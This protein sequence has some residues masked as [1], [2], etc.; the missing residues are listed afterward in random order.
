MSSYLS[1]NQSSQFK[2][3]TDSRFDGN[4]N[5]LWL[6]KYGWYRNIASADNINQIFRQDSHIQ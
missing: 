4:W 5:C 6:T 2:P 3:A 1:L